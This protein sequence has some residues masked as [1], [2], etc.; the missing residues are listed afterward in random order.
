MAKR[1][2]DFKIDP[3]ELSKQNRFILQDGFNDKL[4]AYGRLNVSNT[5]TPTQGGFNIVQSETPQNSTLKVIDEVIAKKLDQNQGQQFSKKVVFSGYDE[6]KLQFLTLEGIINITSHALVHVTSK[7]FVPNGYITVYFYTRSNDLVQKSKYVRY[8]INVES[9]SNRDYVEDRN[10]IINDKVLE[11][12]ILFIDGPIIGGNISSYTLDLIES[13]HKKNVLPVFFVKNSDSNLV[14]D[15][16]SSI[17]NKFNSDLHW[18]YN[19]LNQGERTNFFLYK[20]KVN[21]KNTK[22]FCYFK[23]FN[24]TS[25]LRIEIHPDT[26]V[27]FKDY[28]DD[29]FDLIYYL[30]LVQGSRT[31]LQIRPIAIAEMY[32]RDM[33]NI[34]NIRSLLKNTSLIA[35]RNQERFGG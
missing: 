3:E 23:L 5:H 19:F 4:T 1:L 2:L 31:N 14:V 15:N 27:I 20:D 21:P 16:L 24:N 13:L 11:D 35:T 25:P 34:V 8:S 10:L 9:D 26:S 12:S 33:I 32:A 18:S 7:E 17:K 6:S 30:L 28:L 22:L 29:L